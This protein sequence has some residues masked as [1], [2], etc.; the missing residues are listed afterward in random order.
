MIAPLL[1]AFVARGYITGYETRRAGT[2]GQPGGIPS[3]EGYGSE[4]LL[5]GGGG[6]GETG[7]QAVK[8]G[9]RFTLILRGAAPPSRAHAPVG[10]A[11]DA[12]SAC[13]SL[14][15]ILFRPWR[16][17]V[18]TLRTSKG[19]FPSGRRRTGSGRCA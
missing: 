18:Q 14:L 13:A 7:D 9:G 17:A 11:L 4:Q 10:R 5:L 15:R 1:D 19:A 16:G 8:P 3:Y 6:D 12:C 2:D